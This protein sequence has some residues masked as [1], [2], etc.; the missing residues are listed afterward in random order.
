MQ[1][2]ESQLPEVLSFQLVLKCSTGCLSGQVPS[3]VAIGT[4]ARHECGLLMIHVLNRKGT[5]DP[6]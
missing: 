4:G 3:M 1:D 6:N 5:I 2:M